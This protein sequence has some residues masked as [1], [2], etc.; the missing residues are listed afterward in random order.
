[1]WCEGF[2][3]LFLNLFVRALNPKNSP[4]KGPSGTL[5][6]SFRKD[7]RVITVSGLDSSGFSMAP[8]CL[9]VFSRLRLSR[10]EGV[11]DRENGQE[12]SPCRL[13]TLLPCLNPDIPEESDRT[14]VSPVLPCPEPS[15]SCALSESL[16]VLER[17]RTQPRAD[18]QKKRS[19]GQ[20]ALERRLLEDLFLAESEDEV[21][22]G[23]SSALTKGAGLIFMEPVPDR[24]AR[25]F[26]SR[27]L[28]GDAAPPRR[29]LVTESYRQRAPQ[30]LKASD[31]SSTAF[32]ESLRFDVFPSVVSLAA[33]P[34]LQTGEDPL[35]ILLLGGPGSRTFEDPA[36]RDLLRNISQW[37]ATALERIRKRSELE[38]LCVRDPLTGLLNRHGF[39]VAFASFS[40][41]LRRRGFKGVLGALD[42]DDFKPVNDSWGHPAGDVVLREVSSRLRKALRESDLLGR[43][44]GDEFVFVAEA[45]NKAA[46]NSLMGRIARVFERPFPLPQGQQ[47]TLSLSAGL[48]CFSP[49]SSD[50]D[51]LL[52]EADAALYD[53]KRRKGERETFY[54]L[55]HELSG[56]GR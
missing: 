52:R 2:G 15:S 42:L 13:L 39:S 54:V 40:G 1:M 6:L 27:R 55:C 21:F 10:P 18:G 17:E 36:L 3:S 29:S 38:A 45:S 22:S 31:P 37:G 43:L 49:E 14:A 44:G 30:L 4:P 7:D 35:A 26:R 12:G 8:S 20:E 24:T 50:L 53:A 56:V 19:G 41:S 5:H 28:A 25:G 51:G 34:I 16:A 46:L 48:L 47:V 11:R 9:E 23:L 32:V 33:W